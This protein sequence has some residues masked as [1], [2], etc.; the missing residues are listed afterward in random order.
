MNYA[1]LMSAALQLFP[2]KIKVTLIDSATRNEV[3][4]YKMAMCLLPPHFNKPLAIEIEGRRWQILKAIPNNDDYQ[5]SKRL[6]LEVQETK[7]LQ[8]FEGRFLTPTIPANIPL[9]VLD[10]V[11]NLGF[12]LNMEKPQWRQ[13]EFL[14][15]S[16]L[17]VIQEELQEIEPILKGENL[18]L[19]YTARHIRSKVGSQR[20]SIPFLVFCDLV[21]AQEVGN[22][23]L[24]LTAGEIVQNSFAI[25]SANY[26]YYGVMHLGR[27]TELSLAAFDSVDDEFIKIVNALGLVLI[28]WCNAKIVMGFED[29]GEENKDATNEQLI[30]AD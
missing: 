14:P 21:N 20:L 12:I 9:H 15:V 7:V 25:R 17:P 19:G 22:V 26:T 11:H 27:I 3:G 8:A 6:T 16:L 13:I 23:R 30:T 2:K 28:D 10:I 18:L 1:K 24:H 4:Q 5:Y 29:T